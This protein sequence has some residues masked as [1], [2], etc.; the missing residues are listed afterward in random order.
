MRT[1]AAAFQIQVVGQSKGQFVAREQYLSYKGISSAFHGMHRPKITGV[2]ARTSTHPTM[3]IKGGPTPRLLEK[4]V[5]GQS[6]CGR[7][8]T[9]AQRFA[10]VMNSNNK[11][12]NNGSDDFL[13][14][15]QN[16]YKNL[17]ASSMNNKN[18][19]PLLP[20]GA[21]VPNQPNKA[22]GIPDHILKSKAINDF[23]ANNTM[24]Y[25]PPA[26]SKK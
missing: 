8:C 16:A 13:P 9:R 10:I 25:K 15:D 3:L 12:D 24:N 22:G 18:G 21:Q 1:P 6:V 17:N 4:I 14:K 23:L 11:P 19:L 2:A 7:N 20:P 5:I 26:G